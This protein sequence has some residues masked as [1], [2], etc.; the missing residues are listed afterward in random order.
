MEIHVN[1]RFL[2]LSA[3]AALPVLAA[4]P[5]PPTMGKIFD[6]QL[7]SVE[8]EV[9]SLAEAMPAEKY[10][11]AP[12]DG[13]FK[14]VRT[15]SQQVSHIAY[16]TY[17]VSSAALGEKNPSS[18]DAKENGPTTLK[19][20][21][22]VVKYLKDSFAYAHKATAMLSAANSMDMVQSAFGKNKTPRIYMV[23]VAIWHSFDHYGQM[24]V[25]ARMNNVVPP[26]SR[27]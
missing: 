24:A 25:Y 5:A 15:F 11:F 1:F 8:R 18:T 14:D 26:A 7:T 4:D 6:Q 13:A 22:D 27:Q 12:K 23:N 9:V 21:A 10:A 3:L 20:K 16:V 2:A 19:T 17:A